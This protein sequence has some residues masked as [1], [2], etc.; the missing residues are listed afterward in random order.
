[1]D[2]AFLLR[3]DFQSAEA[4][5][6]P[7]VTRRLD[8]GMDLNTRALFDFWVPDDRFAADAE[9]RDREGGRV[10]FQA[11]QVGAVAIGAIR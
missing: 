11:K 10:V 8:D 6:V 3:D 1:L 4:Q 2:E 5:I 9:N 7:A